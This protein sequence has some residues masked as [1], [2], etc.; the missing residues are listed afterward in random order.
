MLL[1]VTQWLGFFNELYSRP[2]IQVDKTNYQWLV[3]RLGYIEQPDYRKNPTR[4][5]FFR[6]QIGRVTARRR[7]QQR[8]SRKVRLRTRTA[9]V[10]YF[11]RQPRT[12]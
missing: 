9:T 11:R 3:G 2:V 4:F 8:S 6:R 1:W 5:T 10:N 7:R 12:H